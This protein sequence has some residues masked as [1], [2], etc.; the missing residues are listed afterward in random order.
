MKTILILTALTLNAFAVMTPSEV[1]FLAIGKPAF[2]K[3]EGKAKKLDVRAKIKDNKLTG[4]FI[5]NLSE[6][7]TGIDL[8]DEHMKEKYLELK[9]YP[10]VTLTLS[11]YELP[12]KKSEV[13]IPGMLNLHGVKKEVIVNA[14][15]IPLEGKLQI[16]GEL[17]VNLKDYAIEIPSFKGITIAKDVKI[18]VETE[19]KK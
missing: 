11:E 13:K 19:V 7:T 16:I 18:K 3:V 6:L 17:K 2:L 5:F 10:H 8:R 15:L 4:D 1:K 14:M 12:S 9:K